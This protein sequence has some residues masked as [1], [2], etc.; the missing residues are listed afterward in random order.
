L[1]SGD[2]IGFV[3]AQLEAQGPTGAPG[4]GK[5]GGVLRLWEDM[6]ALTPCK[7]SGSRIGFVRTLIAA[8]PYIRSNLIL[9]ESHRGEPSGTSMSFEHD[10]IPLAVLTVYLLADAARASG[11]REVTFQTVSK[12][13]NEYRD[14]VWLVCHA[15]SVLT[16]TRGVPVAMDR[17]EDNALRRRFFALARCLLPS[18]Q[19]KARTTVG[20][21]L[22]MHAPED[23]LERAVFVK[24]VATQLVG[25]ATAFGSADKPPW[26]IRPRERF[27][28]AMQRF[29]LWSGDEAAM[30]L[31][32][33][34]TRAR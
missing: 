1:E 3:E 10:R 21:L 5:I 2:Y 16:W 31:L 29:V 15:D 26:R 11:M 22:R 18:Q 9:R 27:S 8:T 6:F 20:D 17:L 28:S 32:Y 24:L 33:R 34:R 23:P 30:E 12:L 14:L 7:E 13:A 4:E 19:A 25:R